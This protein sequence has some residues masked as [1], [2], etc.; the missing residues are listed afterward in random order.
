MYADA[1]TE[2]DVNAFIDRWSSQKDGAQDSADVLPVFLALRDHLHA[3]HGAVVHFVSR[4]GVSHSLRG[5]FPGWAARPLAVL[6]DV[7]DD[8]PA[9]RWLSVCF[10]DDALTDPEERGDRIPAGLDGN[11]ARCFNLE[12]GDEPSMRYVKD[13]ISEAFTHC[14]SRS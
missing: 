8:D 13:R 9:A 11:D 2:S 1:A 12:D 4:P 5:A 7:V 6:V 14:R 3:Q 10:H